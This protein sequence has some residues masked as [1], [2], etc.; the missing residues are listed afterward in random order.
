VEAWREQTTARYTRREFEGGH[1]F[2]KPSRDKFLA[3]LLEACWAC[4]RAEASF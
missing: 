4:S 1:F 2:I 3:A